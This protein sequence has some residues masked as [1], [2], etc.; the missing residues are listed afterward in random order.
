M[1]LLVGS[2]LVWMALEAMVS[3][4]EPHER[5]PRELA[6]GLALL[7]VHAT[8]I[9]EHVL[10]D[11]PAMPLAVLLIAAGVA[12]RVTAIRALGGAFVSTTTAPLRLVRTGPYR[13][14]RHPSE[15]GLLAAAA[16]A[17]ALLGSVAAAGVIALVLAPLIIVRCAAENHKIAPWAR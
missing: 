4:R 5:L 13:L 16:G 9:A 8:A 17:A 14:M 6:T 11:T 15:V 10:R 1:L 3:T 7:A 2:T 12:L